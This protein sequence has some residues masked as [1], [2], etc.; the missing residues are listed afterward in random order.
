M[1]QAIHNAFI[2]GQWE[3]P[4][5]AHLTLDD[6][7]HHV[8]R[9]AV[10]ESDL[11][12]HGADLYLAFGCGKNE[13]NAIRLIEQVHRGEIQAQL[14]R[15]GF[16]EATRQDVFQQLLL[17]LFTGDCPR[18]LTYAGKASLETWLKVVALRFAIN[19]SPKKKSIRTDMPELVLSRIV[20]D[21]HNPE[22]RLTA[23]VAKP[24]FQ[25]ALAKAMSRLSNRD[26]TILRLFFVDEIS[27]E[28][29]GRLYGVHRA[30]SARWIAEIRRRILDEVQSTLANDFG[31][32]RSEFESL[33]VLIRSQL[34]LSLGRCLGAA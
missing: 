30:T 9:L 28:Q 10:A 16:D 19:M 4:A 21:E 15:A 34:H 5:L 25:A 2:A 18:I 31:V 22:Q 12:R 6:F 32:H 7:A 29:I 3:Y 26:A 33:A 23:E 27:N 11:E 8:R 20:A 17:H 13:P 1:Q 14:T 24:L